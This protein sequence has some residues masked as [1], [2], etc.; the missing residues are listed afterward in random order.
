MSAPARASSFMWTPSGSAAFT[1]SEKRILRDGVQRSPRAG[2]HYLHVAVDDH[3]RPARCEMLPGQ[4]A[5]SSCAFLARAVSWFA[6]EHGIRVERVLTDN[7]HAYLSHR[8]RRA[9]E[10][11]GVEP[12]RTRPDTPRTNGKA[13][14]FIGTAFA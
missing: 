6:D 3:S 10:A 11:L 9:C 8:W 5:E 7:G 4:G 2:W 1:A 14:A 13:E 12:R